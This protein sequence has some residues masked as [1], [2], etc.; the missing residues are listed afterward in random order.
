MGGDG[1][2]I[3]KE[4]TQRVTGPSD[5]DAFTAHLGKASSRKAPLESKFV[6]RI[7]PDACK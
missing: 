7:T 6:P 3:L 2:A 4:G 5:I 1:F